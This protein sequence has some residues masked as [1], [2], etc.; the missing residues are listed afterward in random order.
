MTTFAF[1]AL[2]VAGV[3]TRGEIDADDKQVVVSQLRSRGLTVLDIEEQK[4]TDVGDIF[5]RFKKVKAEDLTVAT[6]QLSTMVSSGMTLLRSFHVLEE[7]TENDKLRET[8]TAVRKD[9]EAGLSLS[10]A[11]GR[12]PDVF[13]DLYV[14]MVTAGESG[15]ILESTLLRVAD[16]LE[17]DDAL[18]RQ[19]KAAMIYPGLIA[20]FAGIVLIALVS[21]LVPVFE[22]IFADF[23]GDLPP[24][25]KFT[26]WLSH[27]FTQRWYVLILLTVAVV[28]AFRRWKNS[29]RG[30]VQWDKLKLKTPM[31]IGD[32]V[33][34]VALARFSR[35]FSGLVAAGV[36]MLE[37]IDITGRT[38]G[39]KVVELAMD[40]VERSV[41]KGGTLSA[42]MRAA[43]EAFPVMVVQMIGVG[44]ETGALEQ[45]L[46]KIADFYEDQVAASLKALTSI[47]EPIMIMMVG[48]IVGFIVIAMYLPMFQVYD[49]IR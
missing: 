7:Q 9:V 40:D 15:G 19:I 6:R 44:E 14:A 46:S 28:W 47:L 12:H 20:S 11:I 18:R 21:F 32:I 42:P 35:T 38:S 23:G 25:T 30:R 34:K 49:Q 26:V 45:M 24:I 5:A 27:M 29:E 10:Q 39:N 1:K 36:P 4:P 8:F 48:G 16:Q 3:P 2:D 17:K 43:P 31:K 22:K 41:K 37:A 13:N 33:Q